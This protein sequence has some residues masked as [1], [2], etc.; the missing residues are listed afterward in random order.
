MFSRLRPRLSSYATV[1]KVDD[2]FCDFDKDHII[3]FHTHRN[4]T[5]FYVQ[6]TIKTTVFLFSFL[7]VWLNEIVAIKAPLV[8]AFYQSQF[9]ENLFPPSDI[10]TTHHIISTVVR[11][12]LSKINRNIADKTQQHNELQNIRSGTLWLNNFSTRN[13]FPTSSRLRFQN[14]QYMHFTSLPY[15]QEILKIVRT[16]NETR[17]KVVKRPLHTIG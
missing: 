9:I 16:L 1:R 6:F 8:K 5:W 4:S 7:T 3:D 2:T 14:S 10:F 17:V 11:S 15:I 12:L 13:T